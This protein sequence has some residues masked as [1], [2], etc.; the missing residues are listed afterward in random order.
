MR[1][2]N[3]NIHIFHF[4]KRIVSAETIFGNTVVLICE[5]D[6]FCQKVVQQLLYQHDSGLKSEKIE[7]VNFVEKP[8]FSPYKH[9]F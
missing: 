7:S 1:K 4:Q 6:Q 5:F 9:P 8:D 3:E 2:L